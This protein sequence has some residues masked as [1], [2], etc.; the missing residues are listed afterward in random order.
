MHRI[1]LWECKFH[2]APFLLQPCPYESAV[3]LSQPSP[4]IFKLWL[5][6]FCFSLSAQNELLCCSYQPAQLHCVQPPQIPVTNKLNL[7]TTLHFWELSWTFRLTSSLL[8]QRETDCCHVISA[9]DWKRKTS[10][11][12]PHKLHGKIA[13]TSVGRPQ[14]NVLPV[15]LEIE[16]QEWI[17]Y[18]SVW[19]KGSG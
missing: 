8:K 11:R 12:R 5:I 14:A 13:K 10:F 19:P 16:K 2:P 18:H 3:F 9:A 7:I 15:F 4:L 6:N 1:L 17:Y